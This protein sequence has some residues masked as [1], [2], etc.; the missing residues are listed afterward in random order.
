VKAT[1]ATEAADELRRK[2]RKAGRAVLKLDDED[3]DVECGKSGASAI[4]EFKGLKLP[5][6][7]MNI[8]ILI[9]GTH[10]DVMPFCGLARELQSLGHRVRV[11]TH[12][13]HRKTVVSNDL[14]FYPLAGDPK[15]L[16]AWMVET[17]GSIWNEAAN[18]KLIPEKTA[19][20]KDIIK[21]CWPAVTQKDPGDPDGEPFVADAVIANPPVI[22]H[23]HVCEALAIPLHI[24]FPQPWYYPTTDYPHPFAGMDYIKG[25]GRNA[26]SY[27]VFTQLEQT[28][29]NHFYNEWRPN[30]LRLPKIRTGS[31]WDMVVKSE[32]PFSAMWSPSFVPK[33]ADWPKQCRVVGT[34]VPE[35]PP[36]ALSDFDT[37]PFKDVI[38]WLDAGPKPIFVGFGSMVI[39][40]P[41][42]LS[43]IIM[44][45]AKLSGRRVV[46]QSGW[47]K[48]DVS[49]EPLCHNVGPCPHD[50]LLP[51]TCAVVHHGGAGTTAAGL[52]EGLPTLVCPFFA[53]QFMWA[54]MVHRAGVGPKMV[55]V[56]KLT[57]EILAEKFVE[58]QEESTQKAAREM[59][60]KMALEDGIHQGL[61]HFL[62]ELPRENML[63]DVSLLLGEVRRAKFCGKH[64]KLC[65]D[66]AAF[67]R[68]QASAPSSPLHIC[69]TRKG[70]TDLFK[71]FQTQDKFGH[72]IKKRHSVTTYALG[73]VTTV[74]QGCIAGIIGFFSNL[75]SSLGA[76]YF[77]PDKYARS[78][79]AC[80]CLF[81][82]V[83]I[84]PVMAWYWVHAIIFMF[85]RFLT[86]I[87]ND[88]YGKS[89][90]YFI[91]PSLLTTVYDTPE[92]EAEAKL[93]GAKGWTSVRSEEYLLALD[94]AYSAHLVFES[95]SPNYPAGQWHYRVAKAR[96]LADA[97]TVQQDS[98]NKLA[99]TKKE[100]DKITTSMRKIG[101]Q[102][103]SFSMFLY[104]I[105][106]TI[107][108][109]LCMATA[110]VRDR[111]LNNMR[112]PTYKEMYLARDEQEELETLNEEA[113]DVSV[114]FLRL[115]TINEED[116]DFRTNHS[117]GIRGETASIT[118]RGKS[119]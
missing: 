5:V 94:L 77:K 18:P 9:V 72:N 2:V 118:K 16:S 81:G 109:R 36:G 90:P 63:C 27:T 11:A 33:P 74:K 119:N 38:E 45:A 42:K 23:I 6:P 84:A 32:I 82:L 7:K 24:M 29:F 20:M 107:A 101:D 59:A 103:V 67:V 104:F 35:K 70:Q 87:S 92:V 50:W 39:R 79:G 117:V 26:T 68:S 62:G 37:T 22:G 112:R 55:E 95:M 85:D 98:P 60:K 80:G 100:L 54:E 65:V 44:E 99:L 108:R 56:T 40:D 86:G 91:D 28:T 30:T 53:D 64:L 43:R 19:M 113:C 46:V 21:S 49:G 83:L 15:Q 76:I 105:R 17:G 51:L 34:F 13:M 102:A 71:A 12:T 41:G 116:L 96:D 10:G 110:Q 3:D 114:N 58:L 57:P 75:I 115:S 14:D 52:R 61:E 69:L 8:C 47:S 1:P 93:C 111:M 78:H 66:V 25:R 89:L 4:V 97:L 73:R 88:L 106:R 31:D 48:M